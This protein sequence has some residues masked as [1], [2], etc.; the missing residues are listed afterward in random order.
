MVSL[1]EKRMANVVFKKIELNEADLH[2][3][4]THGHANDFRRHVQSGT[5]H[6]KTST[7]EGDNYAALHAS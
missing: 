6:K 7:L 4:S 2:A 5:I 3:A 1:R